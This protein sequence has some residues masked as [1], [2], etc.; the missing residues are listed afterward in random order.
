MQAEKCQPLRGLTVPVS[1]QNLLLLKSL[2]E[3]GTRFESH[4][5]AFSFFGKS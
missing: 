1:L 3:L 4:D 5:H 2:R